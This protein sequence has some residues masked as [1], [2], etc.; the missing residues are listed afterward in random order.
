[1]KSP[2]RNGDCRS[3]EIIGKMG[4]HL[5]RK[6]DGKAGITVFWRGWRD[7][8]TI[9]DFFRAADQENYFLS[10]PLESDSKMTERIKS[11]EIS[12]QTI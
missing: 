8:Q 10:V 11:N 4:G 6:H 12:T 9:V 1:M 2:Q 5:G 3:S 7:L